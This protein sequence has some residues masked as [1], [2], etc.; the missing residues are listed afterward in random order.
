MLNSHLQ[1]SA[2]LLCLGLDPEKRQA[3]TLSS[4][5]HRLK[6][7]NDNMCVHIWT[8]VCRDFQICFYFYFMQTEIFRICPL[9]KN[10]EVDK[11]YL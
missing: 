9:M 8:Y 2:L 4:A 7:T 11:V 10:L 6:A 3:L 5:K 1:A